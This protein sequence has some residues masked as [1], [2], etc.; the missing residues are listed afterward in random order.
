MPTTRYKIT[1]QGESWTL[2]HDGESRA[3]YETQE[4]A[5][6][7]AVLGA[8]NDMRAGNEVIIEVRRST[9][10]PEE[11]RELEGAEQR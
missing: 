8:S 5:F 7:V 11:T 4:A 10:A 9:L 3:S 6:E 2:T 1:G